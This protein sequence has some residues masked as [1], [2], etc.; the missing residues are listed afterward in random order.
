MVNKMKDTIARQPERCTFALDP[1]K[2]LESRGVKTSEDA[3]N[4]LREDVAE[5]VAPLLRAI[6]GEPDL[7]KKGLLRGALEE[8]LYQIDRQTPDFIEDG[9]Y[10]AERP[11]NDARHDA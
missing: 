1:L 7:E 3:T 8:L 6:E 5:Q 10:G 2:E 11:F 9:H 4:L